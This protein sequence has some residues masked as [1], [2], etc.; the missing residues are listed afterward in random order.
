MNCTAE[1]GEDRQMVGLGV[2]VSFTCMWL[3]A[4]LEKYK[5]GWYMSVTA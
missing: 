1:F 5:V 4:V 3:T 2:S